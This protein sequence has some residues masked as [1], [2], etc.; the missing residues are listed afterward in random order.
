MRKFSRPALVTILCVLHKIQD[1]SNIV[2]AGRD[3][4][5]MKLASLSGVINALIDGH[6]Y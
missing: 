5:V 4:L 6:L 2:D 1:Q 3:G